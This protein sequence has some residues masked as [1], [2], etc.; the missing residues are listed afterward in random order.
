MPGFYRRRSLD[1]SAVKPDCRL[2]VEWSV[3]LAH[4]L[5]HRPDRATATPPGSDW[6]MPRIPL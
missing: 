4:L 5:A 6:P 2:A 3:G 1:S